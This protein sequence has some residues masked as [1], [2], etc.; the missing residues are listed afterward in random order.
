MIGVGPAKLKERSRSLGDAKCLASRL[1]TLGE[2]SPEQG[3]RVRK[4]FVAALLRGGLSARVVR[5]RSF[6]K[7]V[8]FTGREPS[9][10][11]CPMNHRQGWNRN[12]LSFSLARQDWG[13][14][15]DWAACLCRQKASGQAERRGRTAKGER[16]VFFGRGRI[17]PSTGSPDSETPDTQAACRAAVGSES[18]CLT[19]TNVRGHAKVE[20]ACRSTATDPAGA[21]AARR[22]RF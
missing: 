9:E 1:G 13:P 2:P 15:D 11:V 8:S 4:S 14:R 19:K 6:Q 10:A 22:S 3:R 21:A 20:K 17:E 16:C 18:G 12:D 5:E 7:R